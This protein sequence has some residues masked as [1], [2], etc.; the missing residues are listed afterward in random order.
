MNEPLDPPQPPP[1]DSPPPP[2]AGGGDTPFTPP[3]AGGGGAGGGAGGGDAGGGAAAGPTPPGNPWDQR[4]KL[5]FVPALIENVKLFAL[6][7][8]E[9]W[10]RTRRT[11]DY[12]GPV[13]FG[14]LIG[15]VGYILSWFWS[16]LLG[17]ALN[18][19]MMSMMPPEAREQMGMSMMMSG[20]AS[21]LW[22]IFYPILGLIGIGIGSLILHGCAMLVGATAESDAGLEG[23]VRVVC[24]AAVANLASIVPLVGGLI[25]LVW[26]I[27]LL[28]LGVS[29]LHRTSQGKALLAVLLPLIVCCVCCAAFMFFGVG[30]GV[31][32]GLAN[33]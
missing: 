18:T 1:A 21:F 12:V 31:L 20:G 25:G 4:D 2:P 23:T 8:S 22:V 7:P 24:F 30:A 3:P 9:A 10:A 17:N 27:F 6:N 33:R 29:T 28:T 11:G 26:I 19:W 16:L 5:G 15:W 13:I 14:V 32:G